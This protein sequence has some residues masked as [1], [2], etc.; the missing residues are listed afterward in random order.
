M[1][2]L[3]D[4]SIFRHQAY[5]QYWIFRQLISASRNMFAV[6]IGWQVYDLARLTRSVEES[7][8]LLGLVGLAQFFPV[9]LLSLVGGQAADRYNRKWI[10]FITNVVRVLAILGLLAASSAAPDV[11]LISIFIV[12]AVM[13]CVNA[14]TPAASNAL[15]PT[16]VPR[17]EIP[18]AISWNSLGFQ[19]AA[20]AGP[21][22]GGFL[23]IGGPNLVYGV[24]AAMVAIA[25]LMIYLAQTPRQE[26]VKNARGLK[27]MI[28]GLRY[29]GSNRVVFG[30]ISLDLVVVF[31]GGA[32]ALL[33]VVARDILNVGAEGLGFLRAAPAIGAAIVAFIIASNPLSRRVGTWLLASIAVYGVAM[34]G[35][36]FSKL[37]FLSMIFLAITGAADLIS[38]IIRQSLIQLSTPDTMRGRVASVNF[39]FIS[40]SNELGE[41]ESGVAARFLGPV[42]AVV[43]G[44]V[45]AIACSVAWFRLFPVMSRTDRYEDA[46]IVEK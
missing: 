44:G 45:I 43:L 28:E 2:F 3:P 5:R 7:A 33:P 11:T 41:F 22:L 39:L 25:V 35:F 29:V 16:L 27:M 15:F 32:T 4:T 24:C 18:K 20:I 38:V 31:F 46:A 40:A 1:A 30:A 21:A 34:L 8:F 10:L 37:F 42:G 12:A 19:G 13:G 6:A 26:P 9:L 36:A 14:F 23:Y 17:E